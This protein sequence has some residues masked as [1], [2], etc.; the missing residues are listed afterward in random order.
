MSAERPRHALKR[1][2]Q[3]NRHKKTARWLTGQL[4]LY[5]TSHHCFSTVFFAPLLNTLIIGE[6]SKYF[7]RLNY[8]FS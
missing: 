1:D 7:S 2:R 5:Q 3:Q 6:F 4:Y 8:L